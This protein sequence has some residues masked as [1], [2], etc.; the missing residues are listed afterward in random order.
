MFKK[1]ACLIISVSAFILCSLSALISPSDFFAEADGVSEIAMELDHET[2]LY[3]KNTECK[4]PMASTTKIMT[5]LIICED[6]D[7][8]EVITV[9]DE[10]V[11]VEGSSIYL[12][13]DEQ[14][15]VRDL[16]YGLMLVSGN[17]AAC[18]LAIHHS[19]SVAQFVDKMNE[20]AKELGA[21]NTHFVNPNGLPDDNHYTTALDLC[22]IACAALKNGTFAQVV[23][24]KYYKGEYRCFTNKN[25]LLNSL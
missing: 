5:A 17:D 23:S 10:A 15:S 18:A 21:L 20:R 22:K 8:D 24:T 4:L 7:L 1:T 2:I 19:K 11:G 14:I 13:K 12:K 6:C 9:P 25:K 3:G 16:L